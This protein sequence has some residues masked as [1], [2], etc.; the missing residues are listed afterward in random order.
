MRQIL[1]AHEAAKRF[2]NHMP[3]GQSVTVSKEQT[4]V[5]SFGEFVREC[6]GFGLCVLDY[7]LDKHATFL[8][9]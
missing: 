9:V 4:P 3:I 2:I 1:D 5:E 6:K 7:R 8:R